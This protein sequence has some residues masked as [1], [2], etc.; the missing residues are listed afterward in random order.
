MIWTY[1]SGNPS[2]IYSASFFGL[3]V[4]GLICGVSVTIRGK[5]KIDR[6]QTYLFLS[7][8][9]G[10]FD[11]PIL[12]WAS[13]RELRAVV[14]KEMM[15]LPVLSSVMRQLKFVPIDRTDP[16]KARASIEQAACYLK[17]GISFFAFPE[18]TRSRDGRLNPFKKG[19]FHMALQAGVPIM[20]VTINN[21]RMIQPPDTYS[22]QPGEV[23]IIFHDPIPTKDLT[24]ED[25]DY[26]VEATRTAIASGISE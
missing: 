24:I 20:P 19:V 9:Q 6:Q 15:S 12:V 17:K 8:H 11:G 4:A 13:G 26:L 18:G 7:N 16:A 3:R 21:T 2:F 23:E 22:M 10:N 25:R 1:L 14:K 5:E